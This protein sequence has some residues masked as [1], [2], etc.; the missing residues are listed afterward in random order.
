MKSLQENDI[1][2]LFGGCPIC[3][4]TCPYVDVYRN[5]W[6]YCEAHKVCW[7]AGS[8]LLSTWR[9]QTEQDFVHN[10]AMLNGFEIVEPFWPT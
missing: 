4:N 5:Q 3:R 6:F 10:G 7:C 1:L 8:N 2:E 9:E